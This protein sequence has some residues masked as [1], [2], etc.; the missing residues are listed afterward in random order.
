[1]Q[2]DFKKRKKVGD[3]KLKPFGILSCEKCAKNWKRK[4]MK[5]NKTVRVYHTQKGW[6]LWS[7]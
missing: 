5:D 4:L 7:S 2:T 1:M 6:E 3:K